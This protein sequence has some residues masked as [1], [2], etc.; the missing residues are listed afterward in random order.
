L[1]GGAQELKAVFFYVDES[2]H[3]GANLFDPAQPMLYY[4]VLSSRVDIDGFA[5]E[6]LQRL[7]ARCGVERL[8]AAELGNGGLSPIIEDLVQL[9]EQLDLSFDISRVSKP[10]HAV[11]SF[12][13]QVFDQGLNPAVTWTGYWTALRY[14]LLLKLA[15]LFDDDLAKR[16]WD[17]RLELND[18]R[19]NAALAGICN[20]LLARTEILPDARSRQLISDTLEWA[21]QHPDSLYYNTRT[22]EDR[23]SVMPNI[24]GFQ[25]VMIGI[26]TR[27]KKL[28]RQASRVVVDQQSQFNRAQRTLAEFYAANRSIPFYLGPGLPKMD[29]EH[30]PTVPIEFSSGGSSCGL[31]LVDVYLWIFK[32]L[33]ENRN[34]ARKFLILIEPQLRRAEVS[35]ISLK[36]LAQYWKRWFDELP[37][38]TPEQ[39]AEAQELIAED[40]ARRLR[41]IGKDQPR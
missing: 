37:E 41:A 31:E 26:A 17:A 28:Q 23:L 2:G 34:I 32:R 27:L 29:L 6:Q 1:G 39:M 12:F 35:E 20:E 40:E 15:T 30:I 18:T 21:A 38:P 16:A 10:D 14:V 33:M 13:D 19:A 22:K 9:Q 36:A 7:R 8:H 5:L 24:V 11:M 25:A 3:T 4:G